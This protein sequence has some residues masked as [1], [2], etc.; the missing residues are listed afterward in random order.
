MV[1]ILAFLPGALF[2]I[3]A[4]LYGTVARIYDIM[5]SLTGYYRDGGIPDNYIITTS[6]ITTTMYT[7]AG[8]FMLFRVSVSMINM[9]IEPDRINDR[10]AGAGKLLTRIITSLAMLLIFVPTGWIFSKNPDNPGIL[11]RVEK[12]LLAQDGLINNMMPEINGEKGSLEGSD[13]NSASLIESVNAVPADQ[14]FGEDKKAGYDCYYVNVTNSDERVAQKMDGTTDGPS[15]KSLTRISGVMH[16]T[17]YPDKTGKSNLCQPYAFGDSCNFSYSSETTSPYTDLTSRIVQDKLKDGWSSTYN[18]PNYL[19]ENHVGGI[20]A[21]D[22][23]SDAWY[24][25]GNQGWYGGWHSLDT[26]KA[27]IGARNSTT[28]VVGND[29]TKVSAIRNLLGLNGEWLYGVSDE[30]IDFSQSALSSFLQCT[31]NNQDCEELKYGALLSTDGNANIAD[32]LNEEHPTMTLDF[33][34]GVVAGIGFVVWIALL[35]VDVIIR[36]FKLMLLEMMAP[37]PIIA[38]ADPKD[39]TFN[40]WGKMYIS[41]YLDLFLKLIAIAFAIALLKQIRGAFT[42]SGLLMLF[43]IIAI[44]L[45]AKMVP[46]MISNIFGIKISSGTFK[47]IGNMYKKTLGIGTG[48]ALGT[49]AGV[50]SGWGAGGGFGTSF[51]GGLRG[52]ATGAKAGSSGKLS[53]VL[54]NTKS[55]AAHGK[56]IREKNRD[57]STFWGR[58]QSA[59]QD[60]FGIDSQADITAREIAMGRIE[61]EKVGRELAEKERA[62]ANE[63]RELLEPLKREKQM[64]DLYEKHIKSGQDRAKTLMGFHVYDDVVPEVKAYFEEK[65][66]Y[67]NLKSNGFLKTVID[68]KTGKQIKV[69]M[70]NTEIADLERKVSQMN[71]AAQEGTLDY[72][73]NNLNAKNDKGEF[74]IDSVVRDAFNSANSVGTEIG[75]DEAVT[76]KGSDGFKNKN[77]ASQSRNTEIS[78]QASAIEREADL[79]RSDLN[80]EKR[81]LEAKKQSLDERESRLKLSPEKA[82]DDAVREKK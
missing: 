73:L 55:V 31:E 63:E 71:Y 21:E 18:C 72:V 50:M 20:K 76:W 79:Q 46:D 27:A 41:T 5:L 61:S 19:N 48:V 39:E 49:A 7:L 10:Q 15:S 56:F 11:L 62:I 51:F 32:A 68:A 75:F 77:A 3:L 30:A 60:F 17:F 80:Q 12:A 59:T 1:Q 34:I 26:M 14:F 9:L 47:D 25:S 54:S 74:I 43:Y 2:G 24:Q 66:N 64:L 67:D 52:A 53:N 16:L 69:Q 13:K 4:S 78:N 42:D 6:S 70:S 28:N 37:I 22:A 44:L 65:A 33:M 82:N 23:G 36:R 40:K 8:V 58:A 38:Y 81:Q 29:S 57:G 35:C 45:F